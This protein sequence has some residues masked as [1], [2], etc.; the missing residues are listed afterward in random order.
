MKILQLAKFPPTSYGGIEKL[1]NQ[2]SITLFSNNFRCDTLCFENNKKSSFDVFNTHTV[3]KARSLFQ[4]QSTSFSIHHLYFLLKLR[5]S[6]D[7]FHLH[8]PNPLACLYLLIFFPKRRNLTIHYHACT[9][10]KRFFWINYQ[11]EKP[12]LKR[13]KKIISTSKSLSNSPSLRLYK[14]KIS[15]IPLNLSDSDFNE[16]NISNCSK[17]VQSIIKA[18]KYI[19]F[20]GRLVKYKNFPVLLNAFFR[21]L[22]P[23]YN[24]LIIGNGPEVDKIRALISKLKMMGNVYLFHSIDN[25][26]KRAL[27]SSA[28]FSVLASTSSAEAF[29]YVQ[30]E[31][32]AMGTPVLSF[33]IPF[34]GVG[35]VNK[36]MET[37]IVLQRSNRD[38]LCISNLSQAMLLLKKDKKLLKKISSGAKKRSFL[39]KESKIVPKYRQFFLLN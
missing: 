30:L 25:N 12:I 34:S 27:F 9:N 20:V 18:K 16:P 33:D 1:V 6:Y 21:S 11:I 23:E 26:E 31:S 15:V 10:Y 14:K 13:A 36:N 35:E 32:M 3:Y 39:F 24:L 7:S 28:K 17:Q 2:L 4:F 8:L 37:G 19:V 29:G 22:F 38:D 5:D